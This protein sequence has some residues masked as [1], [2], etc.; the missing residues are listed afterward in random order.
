MPSLLPVAFIKRRFPRLPRRQSALGDRGGPVEL[1][2]ITLASI[3]AAYDLWCAY[4]SESSE[5]IQLDR[6]GPG[7]PV[8]MPRED[9]AAAEAVDLYELTPAEPSQLVRRALEMIALQKGCGGFLAFRSEAAVGFV[10]YSVSIDPYAA[11]DDSP[12]DSGTIDALYVDPGHRDQGVGRLLVSAGLDELR[13]LGIH[14]FAAETPL[15]FR[16]ARRF[17]RAVGWQEFKVVSYLFE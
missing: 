7:M 9:A 10:T 11:A 13:R 6:W 12:G 14:T 16:D 2:P 4:I 17:W 1:R 8:L 5:A 3:E 15:E